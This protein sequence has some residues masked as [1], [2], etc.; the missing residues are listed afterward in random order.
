MAKDSMIFY[1]SIANALAELDADTYKKMMMGVF[2]YAFDGI[3]PDVK[4]GVEKMAWIFIKPQIDACVRR[5]ENQC[6]NGKKG[7]RPKTQKNPNKT[8]TKPNGNPSKTLNDTDT[9]TYND[10]EYDYDDDFKKEKRKKII[11][12]A[13]RKRLEERDRILE[14]DDYAERHE[15]TGEVYFNPTVKL[16]WVKPK[17]D[18]YVMQ[19]GIPKPP[20]MSNED[21]QKM[22]N[23]LSA[24][25]EKKAQGG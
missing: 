23:R 20:L 13:E 17:E 6:E 11:D 21:Y 19:N 2:A 12:D 7:G 4:E 24:F 5:Y 25:K 9:D 3:E 1:R 22:M 8:Q 10:S 16:G 18:S 15:G 14:E